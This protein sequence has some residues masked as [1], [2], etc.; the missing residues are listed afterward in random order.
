[1]IHTCF[2]LIEIN[3]SDIEKLALKQITEKELDPEDETVL[4]NEIASVIAE[5]LNI[6]ILELNNA[7]GAYNAE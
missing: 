5:T 6:E 7:G 1:M 3:L 4:Q 2:N